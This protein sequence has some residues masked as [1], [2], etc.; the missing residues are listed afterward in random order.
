MKA[1]FLIPLLV[2]TAWSQ[3]KVPPKVVRFLPLGQIPNLEPLEIDPDT[4]ARI[5]KDPPKGAYLPKGLALQNGN[6]QTPLILT[7][8]TLTKPIQIPGNMKQIEIKEVNAGNPW[9]TSKKAIP[10]SGLG[11]LY[12]DPQAMSWLNPKMLLLPDDARSFPK[13]HVRIVNTSDVMVLYRIGE[14]KNPTTYGIPPGQVRVKPLKVGETMIWLGTNSPKK[15]Y[16]EAWSNRVTLKD[17]ERTQ[18]FCYKPQHK[19]KDVHV[20]V[21]WKTEKAPPR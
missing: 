20:L 7:L 15:P 11:V 12:R 8:S 14:G 17:G 16:P 18:F 3:Q 1:L 9:L 13:N 21:E 6:N 5:F 19:K 2:A 4:K 10:S